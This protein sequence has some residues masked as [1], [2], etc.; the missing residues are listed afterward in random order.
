MLCLRFRSLS[1]PLVS[2]RLGHSLALFFR[3]ETK[4][5]CLRLVRV[6]QIQ[7]LATLVFRT[8]TPTEWAAPRICHFGGRALCYVNGLS[9]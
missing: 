4:R 6:V 8:P 1:V 7:S 9:I 3:E 5:V 2:C